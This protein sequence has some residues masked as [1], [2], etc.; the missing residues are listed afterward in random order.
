MLSPVITASYSASLLVAGNLKRK[1]YSS[2]SESGLI[3]IMPAPEPSLLDDPSTYIFHFVLASSS[4][5]DFGGAVSS[6]IKSANACAFMAVV[7]LNSM[8]NSVSSI[9]HF[10]NLPKVSG[11][12]I[13]YFRG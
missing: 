5:L 3:I 8:S 4:S 9:A 12:W 6:A 10:N 7:G 11:R 2:S 13:I 1:E